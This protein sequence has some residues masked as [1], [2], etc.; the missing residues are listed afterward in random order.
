MGASSSLQNKLR[1]LDAAFFYADYLVEIDTILDIKKGWKISSKI[2]NYPLEE[3]VTGFIM[4]ILGLDNNLKV[5]LINR[6]CGFASKTPQLNFN[7]LDVSKGLKVRMTKKIVNK[8]NKKGENPNPN[9]LVCLFSGNLETPIPYVENEMIMKFLNKNAELKEENSEIEKPNSLD[10]KKYEEIKLMIVKDKIISERFVDDYI[11]E[12][13]QALVILI[14]EM[15]F[16]DQRYVE[17]ILRRYKDMKKIIIIHHLLN[18]TTILGVKSFIELR[19]KSLFLVRETFLDLTKWFKPD[20]MQEHFYNK[21]IFVQQDVNEHLS[22]INEDERV[23]VV[24]LILANE[25]SVAGKSYNIPAYK[26]LEEYIKV[27]VQGN[28]IYNLVDSFTKFLNEK[29]NNYFRISKKPS[30]KENEIQVQTI[31]KNNLNF[32]CPVI[33]QNLKMNFLENM[34]FNILGEPFPLERKDYIPYQVLEKNN[35][36]EI[37]LDIP[38]LQKNNA[39]IVLNQEEA[40]FQYLMVTGNKKKSS[41]NDMED[42]SMEGINEILAEKGTAQFGP[43]ELK[44]PLAP[45]SVRFK[46]SISSIYKNG[47]LYVTL[48]KTMKNFNLIPITYYEKEIGSKDNIHLSTVSDHHGTFDKNSSYKNFMSNLEEEEKTIDKLKSLNEHFHEIVSKSEQ[49]SKNNDQEADVN[50]TEY[51]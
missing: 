26:Y 32:L 23:R 34:N 18:E 37:F 29:H 42:M 17:D 16:Q 30:E 20:E 51:F 40:N 9:R 41:L 22:L 49:K 2:P 6:I 39:K 12:T 33:S 35:K 14:K 21:S 3:K 4:G 28:A 44:I 24:H 48:W 31:S 25:G 47:T 36:I 5:N 13:S 45:H 7:T 38:Y 19:L 8:K 46:K 27:N 43:F 1:G 11:L 15:K 10:I 50:N